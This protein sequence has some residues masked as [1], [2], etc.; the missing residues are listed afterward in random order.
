MAN[1][2]SNIH[3]LKQDLE[4]IKDILNSITQKQNV[5]D[6]KMDELSKMLNEASCKIDFL[7]LQT[8]ALERAETS[9]RRAPKKTTKT[10]TKR[11]I[12]EGI[13]DDKPEITTP[14]IVSITTPTTTAVITPSVSQIENFSDDQDQDEV[15]SKISNGSVSPAS[16]ISGKKSNV[17]IFQGSTEVQLPII[18]VAK[19]YNKMIKFRKVFKEDSEF[20]YKYL[21]VGT[22][23]ELEKD[24]SLVGLQGDKLTQAKISVYYAWMN[25]NPTKIGNFFNDL[26]K[27]QLKD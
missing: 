8:E 4:I 14:A 23:T 3:Q 27:K 24:K 17:G 20:I 2:V 10:K 25:N 6:G 21:P 18:P 22:R 12:D 26:A 11:T 7:G 9:A 1:G 13:D 5:T 19:K 15:K 16:V